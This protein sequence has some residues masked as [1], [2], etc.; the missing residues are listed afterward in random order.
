MTLRK[1]KIVQYT[2]CVPRQ[3]CDILNQVFL[4]DMKGKG[5]IS[6]RDT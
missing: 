5:N 4:K 1:T 2:K 3:M 6:W